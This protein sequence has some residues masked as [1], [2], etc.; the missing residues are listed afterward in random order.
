MPWL[1]MNNSHINWEKKT[2]SF[3]DKHIHKTTLST[4]L[5]ITAQKNNDVLPPQYADYADVFSK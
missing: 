2:I 1:T 5:T 4:E 3:K